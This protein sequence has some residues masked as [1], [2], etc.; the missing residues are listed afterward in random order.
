MK[1]DYKTSK[2]IKKISV[3]F[4]L[5]EAQ[6]E[7]IVGSQFKFLKKVMSDGDHKTSTYN[8]LRLINLGLF[9]VSE[10]RRKWE[11]KR[12][13]GNGENIHAAGGDK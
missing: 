2:I 10:E 11:Q 3:E 12:Y 8:N 6:V 9:Y 7:E 5:T 1:T 4:D 13:Y